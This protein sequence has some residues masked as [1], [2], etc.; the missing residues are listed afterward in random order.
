MLYEED[1]DVD[2][3]DDDDDSTD[4]MGDGSKDKGGSEDSKNND[5]DDVG[6]EEEHEEEEEHDDDRSTDVAGGSCDDRELVQVVRSGEAGEWFMATTLASSTYLL[7]CR[8]LLRVACTWTS[9]VFKVT[10]MM[11]REG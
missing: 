6:K 5:D 3:E 9:S 11:E 4:G 8:V 10:G 1:K 7:S 2:D